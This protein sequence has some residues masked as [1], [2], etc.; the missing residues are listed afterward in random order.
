MSLAGASV[1]EV[2]AAAKKL[3]CDY[4]L[5]SEVAEVKKAGGGLGGFVSKAS[6]ITGSGAKEKLEA[7]VDYRLTSID[8]SKALLTSSA[9]G[10]N[11]GGLCITSAFG[12][13]TNVASF[14][15]FSKM[16]M[17]DPNMMRLFGNMGGGMG[18]GMGSG[19][20]AMMKVPGMPRGGLDPGLSPF[21]TAMNATQ[22][23]MTPPQQT[24]DGKAVADAFTDTA[25]KVAE[26]LKKKK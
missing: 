24:E 1:A 16:G 20:G 18:A 15:M 2:E 5:F 14:G 12:L 13:A 6:A 22:A 23:A 19:M 7:K 11:G 17:F 10:T 4:I 25:K 21:M 3:E 9:K 26:A 8:G